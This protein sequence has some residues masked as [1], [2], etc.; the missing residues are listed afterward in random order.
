[1]AFASTATNLVSGATQ[2]GGDVYV[3]DFVGGGILWA[4]SNATTTA[5]AIF[6]GTATPSSEHPVISDDGT[7]VAFRD[8][9]Q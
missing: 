5:Q 7:W 3:R 2:A 9:I 6:G 4:S 8:G 1:M